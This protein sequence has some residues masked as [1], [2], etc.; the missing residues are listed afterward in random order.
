M[1]LLEAVVLPYR[2]GV[3]LGF[4]GYGDKGSGLPDAVM[5]TTAWTTAVNTWRFGLRP[6]LC[7]LS[8]TLAWD[9]HVMSSKTSD[10]KRD[11]EAR[12]DPMVVPDGMIP[13][14]P[15]WAGRVPKRLI[16]RLYA[17]DAR[18]GYDE[19]LIDEVGYAF[20]ARCESIMIATEAS[21]GNVKCPCC[22][23]ML[24]HDWDRGAGLDCGCGWSTT[25]GAYLKTYQGKQLSAGGMERFFVE[26]LRDYPRA[27]TP[28]RKMVL[29]DTLI[30]RFH[31]EAKGAPTRPGA[32][33]LIGGRVGDVIAFLDQLTYG[34]NLPPELE[35][36]LHAWRDKASRS[37]CRDRLPRAKP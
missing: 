9:R 13:Q 20:L 10:K 24:H 26:F 3:P 19:D 28:G 21:R 18:G 25:W 35:Q 30:H 5:G 33:N 14:N 31:S 12:S 4:L 15:P 1:R 23:A 8:A 32:V 11:P 34:E 22:G 37:M 16:A 29:I 27:R 2:W 36:N 17:M 6:C 7:G